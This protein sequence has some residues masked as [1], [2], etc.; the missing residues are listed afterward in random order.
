MSKT[1][2]VGGTG[3][4]A[5]VLQGLLDAG[6]QVYSV[7]R[8]PPKLTHE[9][10]HPLLLDYHDL[11]ALQ[12][13][14]QPHASF[15]RAVVW[16]HGSA[17]EAPLVV[18]ASVQGDYFHVLGSAAADPSKPDPARRLRF[19]QLGVAYHEIILGFQLP[20]AGSRW[21]TNAEISAG[22]WQAMQGHMLKTVVGQVE[23]WEA[24]P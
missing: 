14:L 24:R 9:R 21:L 19:E 18:A 7:S 17:P 6:D 10:L 15:D 16:I 5:G 20:Q 22:V 8:R 23:P 2:L 13:A 1:L 12:A 11:D 4:L 3:M